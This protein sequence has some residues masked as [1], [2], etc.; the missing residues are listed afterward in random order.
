MAKHLQGGSETIDVSRADISEERESVQ[1]VQR[2][3]LAVPGEGREEKVQIIFHVSHLRS[4][5]GAGI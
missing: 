1:Y 3:R 2:W 4:E 5:C